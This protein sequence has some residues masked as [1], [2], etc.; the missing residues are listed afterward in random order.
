MTA[1]R[2]LRKSR[3]HSHR[4]LMVSC[5]ALLVVGLATLRSREGYP[6]L[7]APKG[8]YSYFSTLLER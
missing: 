5:E 2:S 4:I 1:C 3:N 8:A 7:G 6:W